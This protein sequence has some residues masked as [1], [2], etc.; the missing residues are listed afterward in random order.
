MVLIIL[1]YL[2]SELKRERMTKCATRALGIG[3]F[4]RLDAK[5]EGEGCHLRLAN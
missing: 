1:R 4:F 5:A 2:A 3:E